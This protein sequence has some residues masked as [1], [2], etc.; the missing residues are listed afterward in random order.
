MSEAIPELGGTKMA[1]NDEKIYGVL[2]GLVF[3]ALIV[4]TVGNAWQLN[5]L[6]GDFSIFDFNSLRSEHVA[7]ASNQALI[8]DSIG[9]ANLC[10]SGQFI[11]DSNR[12]NEIPKGVVYSCFMEV[13]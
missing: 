3:L 5:D 11:P 10:G 2:I 12:L 4:I 8:L 1:N 13:E 9:N 7:L 6:R